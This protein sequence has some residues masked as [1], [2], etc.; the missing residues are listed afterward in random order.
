MTSI[1]SACTPS[2]AND[3]GCPE[4]YTLCGDT[5]VAL[6]THS[7]HCGSCGNVCPDGSNDC[8]DGQCVCGST[9]GSRHSRFPCSAP[10][11]C[12]QTGYCLAPDGNGE[13][14]D[15]IEHIYCGE[16]T[17]VACV[18]GYCTPI[19]CGDP[20][21]CD[22]QDNDCDG[23]IDMTEPGVR[24]TQPC[25]TGP[26]GTVGV[27][28]CHAG[29]QTCVN[30]AWTPTDPLT[31]PGE[32]LPTNENGFLACDG[33]DNNCNGCVDDSYDEYG[34]LQCGVVDTQDTDTVFVVDRSGSM[35]PILSTVMTAM[36]TLVTDYA[37][38]SWL[39]WGIVSVASNPDIV[40][41]YRP[42]TD[43]S[44]FLLSLASL[45][46]NGW[47]EPTYEAVW[48]TALDSFSDPEL[49]RN[50]SAQLLIVVFGDEPPTGVNNQLGLTE[51]DVCQAVA[52]SGALLVVFTKI[53][54]PLYIEEDWDD[55]AIVYPLTDDATA[56]KEHLDDLFQQACLIAP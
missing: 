21:V 23:L 39:R 27:G 19:N 29:E 22:G 45:S 25:Y 13:H 4:P 2:S 7:E 47:Q 49:G 12:D 35:D 55:C 51:A 46:I 38:A 42:L 14:C 48:K 36:S 20:E 5:C 9:D 18:E 32:Q 31:C 15:E 26:P 53:G 6:D 1:L 41:L 34:T 8:I 30:G 11:V 16:D 44:N 17:S 40:E 52:D 33:V 28:I 50:P 37:S 54:D 10:T 3:D 24:L 43:F 56:M